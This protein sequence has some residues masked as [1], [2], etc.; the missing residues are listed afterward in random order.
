[1]QLKADTRGNTEPFPHSKTNFTKQRK[2]EI[3]SLYKVFQIVFFRFPR[4]KT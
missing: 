3:Y 2:D 1:M 4:E